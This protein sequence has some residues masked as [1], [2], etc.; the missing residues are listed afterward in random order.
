MK[1]LVPEVDN[2]RFD[3]IHVLLSK[4]DSSLASTHAV[5]D[6]I[7][8]T[9]ESF[10]LPVEIPTTTVTAS[11]AAEFGTV[12]DI[13]KYDGSTRTYQRAREAYDRFAE[14]IDQEI[15]AL[16]EAQKESL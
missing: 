11:A 16:W 4:V 7:N 6:W 9:Y 3:F 1:G 14:M 5:R 15:V 2:K 8:R 10:V 13:A 12:Y